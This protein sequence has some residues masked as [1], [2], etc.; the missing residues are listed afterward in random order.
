M[1]EKY[2]RGTSETMIGCVKQLM[3]YIAV[4]HALPRFGTRLLLFFNIV[5]VSG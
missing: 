5:G 1:V 3:A 4:S 2:G